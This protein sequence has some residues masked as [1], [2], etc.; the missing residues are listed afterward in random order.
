MIDKRLDIISVYFI[1][2]KEK[3]RK[4]R[5]LNMAS[6]RKFTLVYADKFHIVCIH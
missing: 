6:K 2:L 4:P 3:T 1:Q 5:P